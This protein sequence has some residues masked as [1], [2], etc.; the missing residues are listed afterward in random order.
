MKI[1]EVAN[2]ESCVIIGR[3]ADFILKDRENVIRVFVYG[4]LEDRIKR[5]IDI[6]G[7]DKEKALKEIKRIDKLRSN[8]YKYYTE[9]EWG[10][11]SNY[12]ICINSDALGVDK[13]AELICK[14][15]KEKEK[16]IK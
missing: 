15:V 16:I 13:S 7:M 14:M 11:S 12:D 1:K 10:D 4:S 2:K 8:H 9:E 3:C 6:Y 5:A